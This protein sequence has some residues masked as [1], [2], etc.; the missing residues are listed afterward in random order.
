M[1]DTL[2]AAHVPGAANMA[3]ALCKPHALHAGRCREWLCPCSPPS[4]AKEADA[5]VPPPTKRPRR[6][7]NKATP[8]TRSEWRIY[9]ILQ[10]RGHATHEELGIRALG[11]AV[12]VDVSRALRAHISNMRRKGIR[13]GNDRVRREYTLDGHVGYRCSRCRAPRANRYR[14]CRQCRPPSTTVDLRPFARGAT[15]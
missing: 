8:L 10:E 12:P 14:V 4:P 2:T 5:A 11:Y 9:V 1:A 6:G 13:I 15:P 3:C 7:G